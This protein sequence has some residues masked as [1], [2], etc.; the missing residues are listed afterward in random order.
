MASSLRSTAPSIPVVSVTLRRRFQ[1]AFR[2]SHYF[3]SDQD[4]W[5]PQ[6]FQP[7]FQG[8]MQQVQSW[9]VRT[10]FSPLILRSVTASPRI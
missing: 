8:E 10:L 7:V 1:A 3:S 2:I 6:S 4:E 5:F 9:F